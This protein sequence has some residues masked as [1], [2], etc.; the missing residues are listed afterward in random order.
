MFISFRILLCPEL[1]EKSRSGKTV[2]VDEVYSWASQLT[3]EGRQLSQIVG[4]YVWPDAVSRIFRQLSTMSG[5]IIGLVGLQGVGKSSALAVMLVCEIFSENEAWRKKHKSDP[6][7]QYEYETIR[8][9]WR[10]ESELFPSLFN[11]THEAS[12]NFQK[13]YRAILVENLIGYRVPL[14]KSLLDNPQLLNIDWAERKLG[15]M[16]AKKL[17]QIAWLQM[18]REKKTILIDMPDYSK[19]DR[20]LIAKD[21]EGIYWLWDSLSKM[22][23]LMNKAAPNLVIAIQKEMFQSHFFFDKMIKIELQPLTPEQMLEAYQKRFKTLHPFTEDT[24]LTLARMSRGIFRRFLRYITL[25]LDLWTTQPEPRALI[26]KETVEKAIP[27]ERLV[28]DMELEL[29]EPFPKQSDLKLQAVQ[30]LMRLSESGPKKQSIL[31]GELGLES[32][33]M[34]RLLTKLELHHYVTRERD[35]TDKIVTLT[36]S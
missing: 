14:G 13:E 24:L 4:W 2:P 12:K 26:D 28:E 3:L 35:G 22:L 19:T 16:I 36:K 10:R 15:K 30:L 29:S 11:G 7:P 33:V 5:A 34:S 32:Y 20:R 31:A 9:K 8:F 25:T 21:L 18:L 1:S 23:S 17:R 27:Y 6:S